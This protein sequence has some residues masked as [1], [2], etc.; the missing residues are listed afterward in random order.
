MRSNTAPFGFGRNARIEC[1]APGIADDVGLL[2]RLAAR[3]HRPHDVGEVGGVDIVVHHHDQAAH[4][5]IGCRDQRG[6]LGV[7]V[8]ALPQSHDGHELRDV[9]PDAD[10]IGDAAGFEI[11]PDAGGAQ[12]QPEMEAR[13][14]HGRRAEQDRIVAVVD[15]RNLHHRAGAL[16]RRKIARELAEGAFG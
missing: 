10:H 8:I 15:G 9:L 6:A 7:A 13:R 3:R 2:G 5:A 16:L 12:R 11:A 14:L 4:V 1:R